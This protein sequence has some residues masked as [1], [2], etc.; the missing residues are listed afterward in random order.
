M[1]GDAHQIAVFEQALSVPERLV[2]VSSF[3]LDEN[4]FSVG[5]LRAL[6]RD[7]PGLA[8]P[9]R[10]DASTARYCTYLGP[11]DD[12]NDAMAV[13]CLSQALAAEI[14]AARDMRLPTEAEWE[15]AAGNREEQTRFPWGNDEEDP[16]DAAIHGLSSILGGN[17]HCRFERPP[18]DQQAGPRAGTTDRD[19]TELGIYNLAGGMAEWT[20]D[21]LVPYDDPCWGEGAW[22]TD[23]TCVRP[24]APHV[25]RGSSWEGSLQEGAAANRDGAPGGGTETIGLRCAKDG[26]P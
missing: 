16:C 19:V 2:V 24:G 18:D 8:E 13:N 12:Q 25:V 7:V 6:R 15:F 3:F 14:C 21:S 26:N 23:P 17:S 22:L 10:Y 4:E 9:T 20:S 5:Q 1:Q 11:D